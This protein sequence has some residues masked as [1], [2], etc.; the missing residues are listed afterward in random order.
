[1]IEVL[2]TLS[3]NGYNLKEGGDNGKHI[4]ETIQKISDAQRGDKNHNYGKKQSDDSNKKRSEALT[5]EKN[6][7]YGKPM[8]KKVKQKI[9]EANSGDNNHMSKRVY[10]YD[11]YGNFIGSFTSCGEAG[12]HLNKDR[13][14]IARCARGSRRHKSAYKFK[15]SYTMDIFI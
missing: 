1:M 2:E 5:G 14:V 12:R 9:R 15:W 7:N 8:S 13:S 11:L 6:H 10:Q 3:P 4:A